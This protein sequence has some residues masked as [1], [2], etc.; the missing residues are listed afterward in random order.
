MLVRFRVN[1]GM[2]DAKTCGLD[3]QQCKRGDEVEA[4]DGR[5]IQTKSGLASPAEWL[6][7]RKFAEPAAKVKAV[8]KQSE[9]TA[10]AK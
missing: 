10:P 1:L 5:T 4:S 8:A 9:I 3:W 6:L 2:S 7:S